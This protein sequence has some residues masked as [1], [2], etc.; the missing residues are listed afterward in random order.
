MVLQTVEAAGVISVALMAPNVVGAMAKLGLLPSLRQKEV[1]R[2]AS[3]RLVKTGLLAWQGGKLRLTQK[4]EKEL[5]RLTLADFGA[6]KPRRWDEKW[7]VLTFDIPER[8][9]GLR[10][11]VRSMLQKIGFV[12]LQDSVWAYPYDCED[13]I[14][15]L[16]ADLHIGDALLYMIVDSIERDERLR[17]HFDIR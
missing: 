11:R 5:R 10:L 3:D 2:R 14:T 1:V 16:K 17:R 15:L 7:R 9:K 4:G 12:R 13:L 8:R 6:F